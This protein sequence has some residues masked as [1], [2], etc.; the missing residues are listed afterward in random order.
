MPDSG[1]RAGVRGSLDLT[2][3]GTYR[4]VWQGLAVGRTV[5]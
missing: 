5:R 2:S 4:M 1:P 3:V